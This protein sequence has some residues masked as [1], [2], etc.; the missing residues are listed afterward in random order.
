MPNANNSITIQVT[1]ANCNEVQEQAIRVFSGFS[2][3]AC[4]KVLKDTSKSYAS[5]RE[6]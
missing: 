1:F 6:F 3:I 4:Q 2:S 5:S